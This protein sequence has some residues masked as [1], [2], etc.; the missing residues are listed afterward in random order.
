MQNGRFSVAW[1]AAYS[2]IVPR[3]DQDSIT[4]QRVISGQ[5]I[6]SRQSA[7]LGGSQWERRRWRAKSFG[8]RTL[9]DADL[10][11]LVKLLAPGQI[12]PRV[13]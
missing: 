8:F 1:T 5:S 4:P 7:P 3:G 10:R 12:D 11:Y 2:P 13:G 6:A 9:A